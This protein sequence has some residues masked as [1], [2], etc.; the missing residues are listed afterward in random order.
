MY[1]TSSL[2]QYNKKFPWQQILFLKRRCPLYSY[3][4][5]SAKIR[6]LRNISWKFQLNLFIC[7]GVLVWEKTALCRFAIMQ[8][9][10]KPLFPPRGGE[11][12]KNDLG[13]YWI[14]KWFWEFLSAHFFVFFFY[15][16]MIFW[17]VSLSFIFFFLRIC[18]QQL[19]PNVVSH[20]AATKCCNRDKKMIFEGGIKK[21]NFGGF[22]HPCIMCFLDMVLAKVN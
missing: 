7:L 11:G 20:C 14:K 9:C 1:V 3:S 8:G 6:I 19:P 12:L 18:I 4:L 2:L 15:L 5:D 21:T 17:Q 13:G 22:I 16:F 10:I